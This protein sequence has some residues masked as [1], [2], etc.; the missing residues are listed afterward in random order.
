MKLP[1]AVLLLQTIIHSFLKINQSQSNFHFLVD[2]HAKDVYQ[3]MAS[4]G[5]SRKENI[6][7]ANCCYWSSVYGNSARANWSTWRYGKEWKK[8][9]IMSVW[10]SCMGVGS[11]VWLQPKQQNMYTYYKYFRRLKIADSFIFRHV[12]SESKIIQ[13]IFQ[14][15]YVCYHKQ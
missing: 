12:W 15:M 4:Q 3:S 6:K 10:S 1:I 8:N 9:I 2:V 7:K 14:V 11:I 5:F 13:N